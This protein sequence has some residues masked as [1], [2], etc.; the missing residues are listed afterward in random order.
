M[1]ISNL[2]GVTQA[3]VSQALAK[4]E[5]TYRKKL[6]RL[7]LTGDEIDVLSAALMEDVSE[8]PVRA[9]ATLYAF[10]RKVLADGR[11]CAYHRT[12]YPVLSACEICLPTSTP[13]PTDALR[14]EML[15][16]LE[17]AVERV[18]RSPY[19]AH[20][21]PEVS[22]N[23]AYCTPKPESGADV[24]AIPGRI[25]RVG[26]SVRAVGRP[27]FGG[28]QHMAKVLL[29]V[30]AIDQKVR[31]AMNLR[32]DSRVKAVL[33]STRLKTGEVTTQPANEDQVI[34]SV[35]E[36]YRLLMHVPSA[37]LHDGGIGYEP[38]TYLLAE[39][40]DQAVR[41]ALE[42]ARRYVAAGGRESAPM[43]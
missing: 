15:R 21:M 26:S 33:R 35:V 38:A 2:V 13:A 39:N 36:S 7:G 23:I 12:L 25:V 11:L 20:V 17:E 19:I 10:W 37:V 32:N 41:L 30:N 18:E 9:N 16:Q 31:A 40:P 42:I 5:A 27:V 28:S 4:S 6:S 14:L 24:A 3:A 8:D 22:V 29:A 43:R 1:R 34:S